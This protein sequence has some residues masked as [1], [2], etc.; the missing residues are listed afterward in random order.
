MLE[1]GSRPGPGT[2][3]REKS[4]RP[5]QVTPQRP[6]PAETSLLIQTP[7]RL[8]T[9][10]HPLHFL[11]VFGTQQRI[12][13]R[14]KLLGRLN[15]APELPVWNSIEQRFARVA[16]EMTKQTGGRIEIAGIHDKQGGM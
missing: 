11:F 7:D 8:Q 2:S 3:P 4:E 15:L 14:S 12:A 6:Q 5:P 1:P 13:R 16:A 10:E 9:L